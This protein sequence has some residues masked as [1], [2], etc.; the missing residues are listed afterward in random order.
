MGNKAVTAKVEHL[1]EDVMTELE[2]TTDFTR[3]ELETMYTTFFVA[4]GQLGES[5]LGTESNSSSKSNTPGG[6]IL[7]LCLLSLAN[8]V[9]IRKQ[10]VK[11]EKR[12]KSRKLENR[13]W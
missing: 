10:K 4:A 5:T 13:W 6:G 11:R 3:E 1:E 7:P 9:D 8:G 12:S 2:E